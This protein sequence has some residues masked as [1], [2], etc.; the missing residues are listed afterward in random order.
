MCIAEFQIPGVFISEAEL[1]VKIP[2]KDL[3]AVWRRF[4][5]YVKFPSPFSRQ[6]SCP[7]AIIF[8]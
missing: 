2:R 3:V 7:R 4:C 5:V 6:V 1:R 8:G